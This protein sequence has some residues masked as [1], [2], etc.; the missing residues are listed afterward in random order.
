MD[1][2]DRLAESD[3]WGESRW[4]LV[5]LAAQGEQPERRQRAFEELFELYRHAIQ[6][7]LAQH[8]RTRPGLEADAADVFA[9]CI[10][11]NLFAKAD[12]ARGRFRQYMQG[13][14]RVFVF[15]LEKRRGR[16]WHVDV[17]SITL[18]DVRP[19]EHD[20]EQAEER[21]WALGVLEGG[22]ARLGVVRAEDAKLLFAHYLAVPPAS[23][24]EL[25]A[26][27]GISVPS[28]QRRLARAR[29][30]LGPLLLEGVREG[31]DAA[32]DFDGE[33]VWLRRRLFEAFLGLEG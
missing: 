12:P 9:H 6:R 30:R 7:S 25:A 16:R 4:T 32:E 5:R 11:H 15:E 17:A 14:I 26:E 10:E 33:V 21:A 19:P 3:L 2:N 31:T 23:T 27:R 22:L 13:I 8:L 28:L 1:Q 18:A 24:A 20:P 29:A